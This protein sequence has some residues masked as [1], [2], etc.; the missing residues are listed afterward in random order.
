MSVSLSPVYALLRNTSLVDYPGRLA[1]VLFTSGCNFTCGY[2]HNAVLR[3]PQPDR[4]PWDHLEERLRRLT[5]NWVD[6]AVITGGEP[7]ICEDLPE[8]IGLLKSLGLKIKLDTNGGRPDVLER[9][10]PAVDYVAMDVKCAPESYPHFA[11][12][13]H[14]ESIRE[15]VRLLRGKAADYHFR[16][17]VIES[18]HDDREMQAIGET[19]RGAR[20]Y[21][22]Q[23]FVPREDVA[24]E[25]LRAQP[26]TSAGRL[27]TLSRLM[28]PYAEQVMVLG[29]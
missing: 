10:L 12:F 9:L 27:E 24:D 18:F 8:L 13:T 28:S 1:A 26:R 29:S 3:H 20:R 23:P 5:A 15:S 7:T 14:T 25:R 19:I 16:T 22:L 17:T 2:C 21:V 11:G 4:M 6:A